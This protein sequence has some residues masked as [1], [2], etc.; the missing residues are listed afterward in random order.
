MQVFD[1][2]SGRRKDLNHQLQQ[3]FL[4]F[5]HCLQCCCCSIP[6]FQVFTAQ[7]NIT[8]QIYEYI[9][10]A[11]ICNISESEQTSLSIYLIHFK[12]SNVLEEFSAMCVSYTVG[13]VV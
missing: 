5:H 4:F 8:Q 3:A 11:A 12:V 1:V 7:F 2:E 13:Y 9:K 6:F 10:S